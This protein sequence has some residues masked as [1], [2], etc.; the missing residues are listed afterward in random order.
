MIVCVCNN[1]SDKEIK[2]IAANHPY[3][4]EKVMQRKKCRTQC[5][6]CDSEMRMLFMKHSDKQCSLTPVSA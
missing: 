5:G 3:Q 6:T 4:F 1:I 2:E